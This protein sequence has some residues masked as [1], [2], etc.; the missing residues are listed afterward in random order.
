MRNRAS[1]HRV[2]SS[3]ANEAGE[4]GARRKLLFLQQDFRIPD[5]YTP[6]PS[7]YDRFENRDYPVC[8]EGNRCLG[9]TKYAIGK[10]HV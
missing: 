1:K 5:C 3:G 2:A 4:A 8:I 9:Q 7:L 10:G 6:T